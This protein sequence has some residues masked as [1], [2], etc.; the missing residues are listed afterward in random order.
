MPDPIIVRAARSGNHW[1]IW[2]Y[3]RQG[4]R[5]FQNIGRIGDLSRRKA[6]AIASA[7]AAEFARNEAAA[8]L[9]R[10]NDTPRDIVEAARRRRGCGSELTARGYA[11]TARLVWDL[12]GDI[13]ARGV[14]RRQATEFRDWLRTRCGEQTARNHI[15]RLRTAWADAIHDG[16][17]SLNVWDH[18]PRGVVRKDRDWR[19]VP[20]SEVDT[21]VCSLEARWR[22]WLV[23]ARYAGLRASEIARASWA[24]F[25]ADRRLWSVPNG[26]GERTTKRRSRVVPLGPE[27]FARVSALMLERRSIGPVVDCTPAYARSMIARVCTWDDP[28]QNLRRSC[29][30]DWCS[31]LAPADVAEIAGNS[32]DVIMEFYH[33]VRPETISRITGIARK[34][35]EA[36]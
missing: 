17:V 3:D 21:A 34:F 36:P 28:L 6:D 27:A 14:D 35:A 2:W 22:P 12:L 1:R 13:P 5:R 24:D 23:L 30:S 9:S 26:D 15:G 20:A 29:I 31:F 25:D 19:H 10:S 33:K 18:L 4:R 11:T 8:G 7:K 16:V 32:V